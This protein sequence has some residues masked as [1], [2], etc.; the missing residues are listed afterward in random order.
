MSPIVRL[1]L[2]A[3]TFFCAAII[4]ASAPAKTSAPVHIWAPNTVSDQA[5]NILQHGRA[6]TLD[7]ATKEEWRRI[8]GATRPPGVLTDSGQRAIARYPAD[9][10]LVEVDGVRHVRLTP[11]NL[12]PR[13]EDRLLV[14][15]HGGAYTMGRPEDA[16]H[17]AAA[18]AHSLRQKVLAVRYPLAW[19][20]PFPAARDRVVAVY[21]ELLE[22]YDPGQIAF[23]GNSAGGG[24]AI[25]ALH[26]IRAAGLPS[27]AAAALISPWADLS[28]T[29]DSLHVLD[30]LD[31]VLSYDKNLAASAKLYAGD[32][33]LTDPGVSPIYAEFDGDFPP[34][35]I[36]TGTRDLFL[37]HSVRLQRKLLDSGVANQLIVYEGMWHVFQ[38]MADRGLPEGD[39]AWRDF[40]AF[41]DRHSAQ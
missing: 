16:L 13:K 6:A 14:Y 41:I 15:L 27:P 17:S 36:T 11:A 40:A 33:P 7:L 8:S 28:K 26:Q 10:D 25:S 12:D 2:S 20:Q 32:L 38:A 18:A 3:A 19:R 30:G 1:R 31:P 24:L 29:G 21:R 39:L 4:F 23:A 34:T 35:L 9:L 22:S 37:S 5:R